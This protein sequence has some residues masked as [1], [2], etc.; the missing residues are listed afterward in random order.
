MSKVW[1][2]VV[3]GAVALLGLPGTSS[4][5]HMRG[6]MHG[7]VQ[8]QMHGGGFH[9]NGF[10]HFHHHGFHRS[11]GFSDPR[12]GGFHPSFD[13]RFFDARVSP[14]FFDP[15]FNSS[16]FDPRFSASFFGPRFGG[17]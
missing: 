14:S 10:H 7:N 13:R 15:R 2:S 12:F 16:F 4:A 6:R 3:L 5:Q 8:G 17:F 9:R 11:F 1:F